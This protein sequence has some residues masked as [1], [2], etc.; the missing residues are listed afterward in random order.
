MPDIIETLRPLFVELERTQT[1]EVRVKILAA[2]ANYDP[3]GLDDV[4][5]V[6]KEADAAALPPEVAAGDLGDRRR[7]RIL[8]FLRERPYSTPQ[9]QRL[10]GIPNLEA[11]SAV[12]NEMRRENL[13]GQMGGFW[14]IPSPTGD[15]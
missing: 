12:L 7:D 4:E 8:A 9:L 10:A 5:D 13:V 14:T 3:L 1:E 15:L 11:T 6:D 2:I